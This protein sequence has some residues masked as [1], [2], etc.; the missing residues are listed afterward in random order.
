MVPANLYAQIRQDAV[1]LDKGKGRAAP[2]ALIN[3]LKSDKARA[4]I[5]AYGYNL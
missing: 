5:R 4:V 1:I 2:T 3:Y